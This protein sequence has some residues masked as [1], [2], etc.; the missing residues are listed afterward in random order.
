MRGDDRDVAGLFNE[1]DL[2][3]GPGLAAGQDR[4]ESRGTGAA[5]P[6]KT[7]VPPA[8]EPGGDCHA[9]EGPGRKPP[10]PEGEKGKQRP[11][12]R[13]GSPTAWAPTGPPPAEQPGINKARR[14]HL[15]KRGRWGG[16][17]PGCTAQDQP[18]GKAAKR[19]RRRARKKAGFFSG[20]LRPGWACAKDGGAPA[21]PVAGAARISGPSRAGVR[22]RGRGKPWDGGPVRRPGP[23]PAR[24]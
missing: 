2:P 8:G 15:R 19:R 9:F 13:R 6:R 11:Q 3:W 12:G 23:T 24:A 14:A 5:S 22:K 1:I 20:A 16:P 10:G 17:I 7:P 21:L 4:R 18:G